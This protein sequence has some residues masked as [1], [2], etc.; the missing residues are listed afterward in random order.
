MAVTAANVSKSGRTSDTKF[1]AYLEGGPELAAAL[2]ALDAK[3]K[4]TFAKEALMAGGR[5]IADEWARRVPVGQPPHDPHPGAYRRAMQATD[6]VKATGTKNGASGSVRPGHVD[7]IDDGD[8][9][10]VYAAKLEFVTS[11]PS[12]RPAFDASRAAAADA[13]GQS[14]AKSIESAT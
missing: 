5:V 12:A 11:E 13:I 2:N 14:L 1:S 4:K 3:L 8:Q 9:P 10:A 6:A 7:G